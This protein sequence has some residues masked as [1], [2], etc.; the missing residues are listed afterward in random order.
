MV[1]IAVT[2]NLIL[3]NKSEGDEGRPYRVEAERIAYSV[4]HGEKP[5]ESG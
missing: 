1:L 3:I 2:V 5:E 4:E